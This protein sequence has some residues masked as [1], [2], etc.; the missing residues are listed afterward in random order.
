[1]IRELDKVKVGNNEYYIDEKIGELRNV[2][3]P[4]DIKPLTCKDCYEKEVCPFAYDPDNID[5]ECL[6]MK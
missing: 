3:N 4:H 1:M 2:D 6:M 5:G